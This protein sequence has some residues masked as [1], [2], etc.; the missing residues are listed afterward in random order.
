MA[1][2]R[3]QKLEWWQWPF[4]LNDVL[5]WGRKWVFRSKYLGTNLQGFVTSL[6]CWVCGS[7][8]LFK[9]EGWFRRFSRSNGY[10]SVWSFGLQQW[11]DGTLSLYPLSN[12]F[13]LFLSFHWLIDDVV[14]PRLSYVDVS[15]FAKDTI[16]TWNHDL[17]IGLWQLALQSE[18][19]ST[20][21][22]LNY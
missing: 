12:I 1:G 4:L 18:E 14:E 5:D 8:S 3:R 2:K 10:I 16:S 13:N 11:N 19:I 20:P 22:F 17:P 9:S 6:Q 21:Q 7:C 15:S